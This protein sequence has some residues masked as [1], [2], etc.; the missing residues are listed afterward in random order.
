MYFRVLLTLICMLV[1]ASTSYAAPSN[2]AFAYIVNQTANAVKVVDTATA[3]GAVIATINLPFDP[4]GNAAG[5]VAVTPDGTKV[6]VA[7]E[8]AKKIYIIDAESRTVAGTYPS[9]GVLQGPPGGLAVNP[10]GTRLYVSISDST[11]VQ[12]VELSDY[13]S[14]SVILDNNGP[15]GIVISPDGA[16]AYVTMSS[17]NVVGKFDA[18]TTLPSGSTPVTN[19]V[20]SSDAFSGPAG[21]AVNSTGSK[22]FV[23]NSLSSSVAVVNTTD[24]TYST[25]AV[26]T[27]PFGVAVAG[28]KV[29]VASQSG[30]GDVNTI[31]ASVTPPVRTADVPVA[32]KP[33]A[34]AITP[35]GVQAFVTNYDTANPNSLY[36]INTTTNVKS[37]LSLGTGSQLSHSFGDFIG[38]NMPYDITVTAVTGGTVTAA[39]T[40]NLSGKVVPVI[41]GVNKTFTF[42]PNAGQYQGD[43]TIDSVNKG[44]IPQYTFPA[45]AADHTVTA[46]FTATPNFPLTVNV[47]GQGKVVSSPVGIDTSAGNNVAYFNV[48]VTL[49]ATPTAVGWQF[50]SWGGDCSGTTN[51]TTVN[52]DAAKTC[53]ALFTSGDVYVPRLLNYFP[54]LNDACNGAQT[55]DT[56]LIKTKYA[57]VSA[58]ACSNTNVTSLTIKGGYADDYPPVTQSGYTTLTGPV[59]INRTALTIDK[60]IIK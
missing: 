58:D 14:R 28:N 15:Q 1:F 2:R 17:S 21:I 31:D 34:I 26:D 53:T 52:V 23:A 19:I 10:A 7:D 20:V 44:K 46:S 47:T 37:T 6:F 32:A 25:V 55:G 56:F 60:V 45:L 30:T 48:V 35:D 3:G 27:G 38:P 51:P 36:A 54:T 22:L 57:N 43:K 59:V 39:N 9:S 24:N 33:L 49:T 50:I 12:V 4:L 40:A 18:N 8:K 11:T 41:A 13:T 42:T 5:S 29:F 16:S